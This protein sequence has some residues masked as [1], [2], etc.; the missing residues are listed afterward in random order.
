MIFNVK[1]F[2]AVGDGL[3]DDRLA[4]QAAVNAARA[5]GGGEVYI[6]VGIYAV[7]GAGKSSLGAIQ[8]Y[9]NITVYGDGMGQSVVKVKD[10][11]SGDITG[12]FR[13][14]YGVETS[15]VGMH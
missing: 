11:W 8:L 2:G 9:D 6:P 12:V 14:P 3:T 10:G 4:I 15:N 5:A 1:D 13:T 7:T